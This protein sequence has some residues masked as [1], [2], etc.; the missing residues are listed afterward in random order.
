MQLPQKYFRARSRDVLLL[1]LG[2][3]NGG[4]L[5]PPLTFV[6]ARLRALPKRLSASSGPP[7]VLH[8]VWEGRVSAIVTSVWEVPSL[9]TVTGILKQQ[10]CRTHYN[11]CTVDRQWQDS[12]SPWLSAGN[13]LIPT[14]PARLTAGLFH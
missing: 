6:N 10:N 12:S 9:P 5:T 14:L 2:P 4:V 8:S 3:L 1:R 7:S 11:G 13:Y